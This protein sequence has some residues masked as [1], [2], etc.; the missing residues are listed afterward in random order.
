ML[1]LWVQAVLW[2]HAQT[3]RVFQLFDC[4]LTMQPLG[5]FKFNILHRLREKFKDCFLQQRLVSCLFFPQESGNIKQG[6][7]VLAYPPH[8][9]YSSSSSFSLY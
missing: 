8:I 6:L 7:L 4:Q 9:N 3:L 2:P 5:W 1:W